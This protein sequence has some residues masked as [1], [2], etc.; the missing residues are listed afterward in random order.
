MSHLDPHTYDNY[1][2]RM[3]FAEVRECLD[4]LNTLPL[5]FH[6]SRLDYA[7]RL[8]LLRARQLQLARERRDALSIEYQKAQLES[9]NARA[10]DA[11]DT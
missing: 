1:T 10:N 9:E 3:C 11:T 7:E 5:D 8:V 6:A 4:A 2:A